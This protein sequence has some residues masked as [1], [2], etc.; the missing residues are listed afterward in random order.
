MLLEVISGHVTAPSTT[1]TAV[2]MSTGDLSTVRD[3]N[4]SAFSAYIL[5]IWTKQQ[6]AGYIQFLSSN[7]HEG[8]IGIKMRSVA[9][10]PDILT[11]H[12]MLQPLVPNDKLTIKQSGSA[13]SGDIEAFAA[14]I[15]YEGAATSGTYI[16]ADELRARGNQF[17]SVENTLALDTS[18]D[19][20]GS[21]ALNVEQDILYPDKSYALV[22]GM[23]DSVGLLIGYRGIDFGNVRVAFPAH[24]TLKYMTSNFFVMLSE[25]IRDLTGKPGKTIP[26]LKGI[27]KGNILVDGVTDENGVDILV[28]THLI[29]LDKSSK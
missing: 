5:S 21:E 25:K 13:T 1:M 19:Y 26:V 4:K 29:S 6:T 22:G 20:S 16:D 27:N 12:T 3:F 10:D 11:P 23:V 18:G 9:A 7:L 2:T 28:N 8:T 14:L 15:M 17:V 24:P